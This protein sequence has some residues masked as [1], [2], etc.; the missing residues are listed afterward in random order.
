MRPAFV[1]IFICILTMFVYSAA[2]YLAKVTS[3]IEYSE[4]K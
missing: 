4:E 3:G 2:N 1:F